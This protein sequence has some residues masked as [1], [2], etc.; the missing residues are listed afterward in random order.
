MKIYF[1]KWREKKTYVL[2]NVPP[3][4]SALVQ[5]SDDGCAAVVE[6]MFLLMLKLMTKKYQDYVF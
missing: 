6:T 4:S 5:V 1:I 2:I 3:H